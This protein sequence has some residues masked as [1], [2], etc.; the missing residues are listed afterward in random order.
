VGA[1]PRTWIAR[2]RARGTGLP[3]WIG[4]PASIDQTRLLRISMKIGLGAS[5]RFLRAHRGLLARV[6]IRAFTPDSLVEALADLYADPVVNVG[7][8][9]FYTFYEVE[10][11]ERWRRETIKRLASAG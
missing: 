10:R 8:F 2:V 5:A 3:V 9:H 7:G 1:S 6:L 11:I 4:L